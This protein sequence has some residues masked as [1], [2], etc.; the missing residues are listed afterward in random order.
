MNQT[1]QIAPNVTILS[2]AVNTGL[3]I[4]GDRGILIDCCD[5]VTPQRLRTLGVEHVDMVLCSQHRRPNVAGA[6]SFV[7]QGAK[8][9]APESERRLFENVASYWRDPSNRWHIYHHQPSTQ[10]LTKPLAVSQ[11]VG[12]GDTIEW[13]GFIVRVIETPGATEGSLS[14]LV[15]TGDHQTVCFCGDAIYAPGQIWDFYSLQRGQ[16]SVMDYHGFLGNHHKL[17]ETLQKLGASEADILVPSHGAIID[18]PYAATGLTLERLDAA[19]RNYA[20]ISALHY[21]FPGYLR[22]TSED[23]WRMRPARTCPPPDIVQ[24]CPGTTSFVV[25]S[26]SDAGLLIDCG[27]DAVINILQHWQDEGR[28]Q[29]IEYCWLT[30]YHDDHVDVLD[31]GRQTLGFDICTDEHVAEII[32]HPTRFFLPCISPTSVPVA[33]KT[34][35]GESWQWHEFTLTGFHFPGQSLYHSGLLVEGHGT[36][37]FFAGDSGAP[38]GLDDYCCGNRNFL[39]AGRGFRR[40]IEIWRQVQPQ[41]ILNQHQEEAF[42]FDPPTLDYLETMLEERERLFAA[43][44][45]WT[46]PDFGTDEHWVRTYPYEQTAQAGSALTIEVQFTNHSPHATTAAIEP[47]V[48][49]GWGWDRARSRSVINVPARTDGLNTPFCSRPDRAASARIELPVDVR[50]GQHIV[51]F[52]ITWDGRYLGQIRHAIVNVSE[53]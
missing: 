26:D 22:E 52:R 19:W 11:G 1:T 14:F 47:V 46:H 7:A 25:M 38:S 13:Q 37:V 3:L 45:P 29:R 21:Y 33:R 34:H 50:P 32:E 18:A 27:S 9:I 4:S 36:S 10:V 28:L 24:R 39:G 30:H 2:G 20:A 43:I 41:F 8:L 23:P 53:D 15:Q 12:E 42:L 5:S 35:D 31:R 44:L 49:D 48:P 40:C 16:D 51:P 6:Y 17:I